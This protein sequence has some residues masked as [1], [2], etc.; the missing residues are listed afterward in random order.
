MDSRQRDSFQPVRLLAVSPQ[1]SN[2]IWKDSTKKEILVAAW[3]NSDIYSRIVKS[4]GTYQLTK[5]EKGT[6]RTLILDT[7]VTLVP[8]VREF[9]RSFRI[10]SENSSAL[11]LT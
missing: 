4:G 2:L 8:Q 1:N 3:I 6:Q 7:W 9:C 10:T 11:L 5:I